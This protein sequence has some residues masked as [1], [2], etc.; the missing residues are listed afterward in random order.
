MLSNLVHSALRQADSINAFGLF[1]LVVFFGFF[2][3]VLFWAFRLKK[4]YLNHM[5]DLP[6]DGGEKN[7]NDQTQSEKL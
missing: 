1:S 5:G 2:T 6:L 4:N 7:S 3:G